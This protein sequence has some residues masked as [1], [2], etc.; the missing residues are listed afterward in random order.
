M[1]D[2]NRSRV[3]LLLEAPSMS[4]LSTRSAIVAL[5]LHI[6]KAQVKATAASRRRIAIPLCVLGFALLAGCLG[7]SVWRSSRPD[8]TYD[9]SRYG[10]TGYSYLIFCDGQVTLVTSES[11][12]PLGAYGQIHGRW[13]WADAQ[14]SK[15]YLR[16]SLL[17]L[18]IEDAD[19]KEAA[20]SPLR[21]S[22]FTRP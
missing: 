1:A 15:R 20:D 16:P 5:P 18:H 17:S 12:E 7:Y 3:F 19:G 10:V 4:K 9:F 11:R 2:G 13:I 21:R 14:G 22:L 6:D 8:G